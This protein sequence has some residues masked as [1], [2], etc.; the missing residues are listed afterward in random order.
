VLIFV[1]EQTQEVWNWH[2]VTEFCRDVRLGFR[3]LRRDQIFAVSVIAIL[4]LGIAA[5]VTMFS[6]LNAVRVSGSVDNLTRFR[7]ALAAHRR[8]IVQMIVGKGLR[9]AIIGTIAGLIGATATA[10]VVQSLLYEASAMRPPTSQRPPSS[11]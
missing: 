2:L 1:K 9:L 3:A 5:T 6:V 4:A 11:C 10:K 8:A 7:S